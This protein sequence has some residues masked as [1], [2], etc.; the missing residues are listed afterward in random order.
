MLAEQKSTDPFSMTKD[1]KISR[2]AA[3]AAPRLASRRRYL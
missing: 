2:S 1:Q 3:P